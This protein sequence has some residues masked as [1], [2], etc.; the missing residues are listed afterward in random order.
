MIR[1]RAARPLHP[2]T[3]IACALLTLALLAGCASDEDAYVETPVEQLYNEAMDALQDEDYA[4]A[5]ERFAEV[6]RQHPYSSWSTRAQLMAAFAYYEGN[7]YDDAVIA[8]ERFI[9]LH[10][11]HENVAYAYYLV[12]IS[13]Y[14]RISNVEWDQEM[15][16]RALSALDEVVRRFPDT[17]YARDASLKIDLTEDHLAGKE[18]SV[19]RFYLERELYIGAIK[20]FRRVVERYQTTSHTAE[21][22]HRLVEA[23]LAVGL[24]AEA[25]QTAAVLGYNYPGS[26]WYQYSYALLTA[27]DG[28]F[29]ADGLVE[30]LEE[31]SW[32]SRTFGDLF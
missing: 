5:A 30:P 18:M 24:P 31:D 25:R 12:A 4:I 8:A 3:L 17:N 28:A 14:E 19:G 16:A 6:E 10:P 7:L 26:E 20:R 11:G 22:L 32:I 15:T 13:Y 29:A 23:Y 2:T 21:A 1:L 9:E 27:G